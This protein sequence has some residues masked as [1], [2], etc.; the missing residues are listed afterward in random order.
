MSFTRKLKKNEPKEKT[1]LKFL[2]KYHHKGAFYMDDA[3]VQDKDDVR[4]RE[5]TGATLEDKF[6]KE[7]LPSVMQ[8]K[9]FG[10][11]GRCV[12]WNEELLIGVLS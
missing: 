5:A 6:N 3:S 12:S 9:N 10:K 2:Q 8:V 4:R 7:V 1:K 11:S